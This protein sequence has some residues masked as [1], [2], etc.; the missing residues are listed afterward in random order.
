MVYY[1][2]Y[3][4]YMKVV[5]VCI[6]TIAAHKGLNREHNFVMFHFNMFFQLPHVKE[7]TRTKLL[8]KTWVPS[9]T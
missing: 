1:F 7:F 3:T 8:D 9:L 2:M 6:V 4:L 5:L